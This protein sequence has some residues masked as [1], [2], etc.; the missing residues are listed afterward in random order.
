MQRQL[1]DNAQA[2][3]AEYNNRVDN[4]TTIQNDNRNYGGGG[5]PDTGDPS[6]VIDLPGIVV[7]PQ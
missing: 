2:S 6:G 4:S 1:R 5:G 3:V 7:R